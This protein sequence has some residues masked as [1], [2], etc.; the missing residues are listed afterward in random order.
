MCTVNKSIQLAE[1]TVNKSIQLAE[2]TVNK[3]IQLYTSMG[4]LTKPGVSTPP[5]DVTIVLEGNDN[6]SIK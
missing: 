2:Y 4:K 3:S 1:Y 6:E 5:S